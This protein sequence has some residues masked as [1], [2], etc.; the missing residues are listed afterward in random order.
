M[1][2][3]VRGPQVARLKIVTDQIAVDVEV[4]TTLQQFCDAHETSIVFGCRQ[5]EC[6]ACIIRVVAGGENLSKLQTDERNLLNVLC[7]ESDRRL[8]CQCV[9]VG[10]VTI[11]IVD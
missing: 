8:A 2:A 6:G 3:K 7:A 10:D 1:S 5:A 9:V 4:G 11:E